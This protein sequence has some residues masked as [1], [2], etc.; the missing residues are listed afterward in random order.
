[1]EPNGF[2]NLIPKRYHVHGIILSTD[3]SDGAEVTISVNASSEDD[4]QRIVRLV[5]G[6][7][8][9]LSEIERA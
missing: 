4:A 8:M 5:K 9:D 1:M 2:E 3:D 6:S 7:D